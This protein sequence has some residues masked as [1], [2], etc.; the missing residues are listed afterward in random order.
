MVGDSKGDIQAGK[1]A[2]CKTAFISY[3]DDC[4]EADL[5]VKSVE[6][7]VNKVLKEPLC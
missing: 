2:S 1:A 6:D 7:F 5:T 4:P 3:G